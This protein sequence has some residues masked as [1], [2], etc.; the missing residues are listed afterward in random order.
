MF[1]LESDHCLFIKREMPSSSPRTPTTEERELVAKQ[2]ALA[3]LNTEL[4]E[5]E[6]E[7]ANLQGELRAFEQRRLRAGGVR[8]AELEAQIAIKD[9]ALN[10]AAEG[11]TIADARLPDNPLIYV[12]EGFERATGYEVSEVL[13][14]NCRFLQGPLTDLAAVAEIRASVLEQR[15]CVVE[16]LNYRKDQSIFWNRL[17]ITPVRDDAGTVTHFIGIQSDITVRRHAE[18]A[19]R[20]TAEAIERELHLAARVQQALLP[21][22]DTRLRGFRVARA[23][24]PCSDLA[25]DTV[26]IVPLVEGQVGIYLV[27]VSGHGVGAALLSFTLN[28]LLSP[29]LLVEDTGTGPQAV[30]PSRVAARLNRQFP[31]NRTG[32][33]FTLVYGVLEESSGVFRYVMAGHPAPVL[34]HSGAATSPLDGA[35]FP[36]GML[37]H[38]E[39][40]DRSVVLQPGDRLCLY[41]DGITDALDAAE[42]EFGI[43]RLV[44][45]LDRHRDQ[46]LLAALDQIAGA[47]RDWSGSSLRDDVTLL[48]LERS[49]DG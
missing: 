43:A 37:D 48:A 26:G 33:Y 41:T 13:G 8:F 45:E 6:L 16:I 5:R 34:Q 42:Q 4:A 23:F 25:G 10:V 38:V 1:L 19:L 2:A 27:D 9:R 22:P 21:P 15:E 29:P 39:F 46:P 49:I 31:M 44:D 40:E 17:S 11:V 36:I 3:V 32:Q 20:R 30:A 12:N 18:Q 35:G 24:H 47:V 14:R 7:L 28:H